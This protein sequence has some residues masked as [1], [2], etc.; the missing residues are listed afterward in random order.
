[1]ASFNNKHKIIL[2]IYLKHKTTLLFAGTTNTLLNTTYL[3]FMALRVLQD[4]VELSKNNPIIMMLLQFLVK[5]FCNANESFM[6]SIRM[7]KKYKIIRYSKYK[8]N[9]ALIY[10]RSAIFIFYEFQILYI[11]KI[12]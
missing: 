8:C 11:Y 1:M 6:R 7:C 9:F 2:H 5:L 10:N 4:L 3:H 12:L